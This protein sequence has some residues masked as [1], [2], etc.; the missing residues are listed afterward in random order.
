MTS[1]KFLISFV[2]LHISSVRRA[3]V[4]LIPR[5]LRFADLSLF[6]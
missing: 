5:Y 2:A 4:S 1:Q 3:G 6:A